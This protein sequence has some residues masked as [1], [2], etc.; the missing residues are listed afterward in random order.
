MGGQE[1]LM[2]NCVNLKPKV[3]V[4]PA[5]PRQELVN[6]N[7]VARGEHLKLRVAAYARVSTDDEE[8]ESSYEAQ[9]KY[10]TNLISQN[11]EWEM[12]GMFADPGLSGKNVKRK[13]FQLLMEACMRGEVDRIIT[14]SVSR[15]ARNTLD[16]VECARKLKDRGIGIYFEKEQLDTLQPNSEFILTIMASLAEEESRSISNNIRWSYKKKFE[17]GEV[18]LTTKYLLGYTRNKETNEIEIIPDEA[19]IVRRI[20]EEYLEGYSL[21]E[22]AARLTASGIKTPMGK[23]QWSRS[24]IQSILT[25]EKYKGDAHLQKT[26]LPDFL[27][28]RRMKNNGQVDSWY[29]EN[30]HPPI[31][32]KEIFA[33]V[34]EEFKRRKNLRSTSATGNGKFSGKYPFS[35]M[36][37]C[38]ECGETYRRHQ[39]HNKTKTYY[40]WACKVHENKGSQHCRAKPVYEK[41]LEQAFV[42]ALNRLFE[43]KQE[44]LEQLQT[45]VVSEISDSCDDRTNE[46]NGA[47]QEL[48]IKMA[49]AVTMLENE[50]I[51][52]EEYTRIRK[53]I[54]S[55]IDNLQIKKHEL[56]TEQ[57]RMQ[58]VEYRL[59]AIIQLLEN[60][61]ML[62][63][64]DK[65]I[66]KNLVDKMIVRN[67]KIDIEFQCGITVTEDL[68]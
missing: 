14:K 28:P 2:E 51:N 62:Q 33:M 15:F 54:I 10:F 6:P 45:A 65:V 67:D 11:D 35:G 43:N 61:N 66:F 17:N 34:K 20:Y 55:Q 8:Q 44:I 42:R 37:I 52:N 36:V 41:T 46:I 5:K 32:S 19:V 68:K 13:Q 60:G 22:I 12:V 29:V 27:S 25:N 3:T 9:I 59:D 50:Q 58:L 7:A 31:V 24:T 23:D 49:N 1:T 30:S 57:S 21:K 64:F 63:T 53:E 40:I 38:G 56:L 18:V 48:Q 26:Y 39:Q 16:C 47:I 4:I